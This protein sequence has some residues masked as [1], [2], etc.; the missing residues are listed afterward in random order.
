MIADPLVKATTMEPFRWS[1]QAQLAFETLKQA[2]ST[3]P[4]LTLPDFTLPFTIETDA[5]GVGMG[6]VL[7]Q[8]NHPIAYFSKPFS[9]K[10]L[11]ASTYV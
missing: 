7:S 1:S 6:A 5:S 4:V 9:K 2:L 3:A 8:N 10:V 11:R